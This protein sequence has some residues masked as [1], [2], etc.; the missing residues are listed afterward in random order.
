VLSRAITSLAAI[1]LVLGA[2][3]TAAPSRAAAPFTVYLPNVTKT[4]GGSDGW[5]TP[6]IVQNVGTRSTT[7][8][9]SYYKFIDGSLAA[10]R[11]ATVLPGR[12]YVDS[13]RDDPDLADNGQFSVVITSSDAPVVA[14]VNE[15]HGFD[16]GDEALS[17][18]GIGQGATPVFVPLVYDAVDDWITTL[19]IQNVSASTTDVV[20]R[21]VSLDGLSRATIVRTIEPGRSKFLDPRSESSLVPGTI[22]SVTVSGND[23]IAVVSNHHHDLPGVTPAMGDSYNAVPGSTSTTAYLPY[24]PVRSGGTDVTSKVF[25][26]N[27]GTGVAAPTFTFTR[28]GAPPSQQDPM[29]FMGPF[30]VPGAGYKLDPSTV[31]D[32]D[33]AV[34]ITGGTF[35]AAAT[36]VGP[37]SAMF[38][39]STSTPAS[40]LYLPNVTRKL[41]PPGDPGWTTPIYLQPAT[42]TG[43]TLTWYR[44]SDGSLVTTQQVK[45][46][47]GVTTVVDPTKVV[48]L[49]DNSQYAVVVES[50]GTLVAI[51]TEINVIAGDD[52]M[53]YKAFP[54]PQ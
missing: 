29:P 17:Y 41:G 43:A 48:G 54:P 9:V 15:H 44:F 42:A 31:P 34:T 30:L 2:V 7:L 45:L 39:T 24:V 50:T 21:F 46:K 33:F 4:L 37:A 18:S 47:E 22:Y 19:V 20:A 6:F 23:A 51:V 28:F 27:A 3:T 16:A 10:T 25:V 32:G 38:Y 12:S 36:L 5:H 1:A 49:T 13:P 14:L 40:V 11:R 26:Q 52:A 8:T 53:V 35:V